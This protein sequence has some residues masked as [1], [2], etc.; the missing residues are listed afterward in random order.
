[1]NEYEVR[2]LWNGLDECEREAL[3]EYAAYQVTKYPVSETAVTL[4]HKGLVTMRPDGEVCGQT[5]AWL[6]LTPRG[7]GL[8]T[9]VQNGH[10]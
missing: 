5:M 9:W 3:L 8:V 1:M 2:N 7:D 6:V 4:C 10:R